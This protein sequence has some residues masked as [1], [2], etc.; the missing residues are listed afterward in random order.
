MERLNYLV[1]LFRHKLRLAALVMLVPLVA[2]AARIPTDLEVTG[3]LN[4]QNLDF[5]ANTVRSTNTNGSITLAP[6]GTGLIQLNGN[7]RFGTLTATTVPYLDANK[8]LQ[9]SAVTPTELGYLS[10]V[11]SQLAGNDDTATLTNKTLTSPIVGTDLQLSNQAEAKFYEQTVNGTNYT[12]LTGADSIGSDV[13]FKLPSS[14]G[15]AGEVI[16]TDGS[17]NLS[18][19]AI[20]VG[21]FSTTSATG[22]VSVTNSTTLLLLDTSSGTL[23]A[24]LFT[25]V[26][27][28]G[29]S[30]VIKKI[31]S[32]T[33]G[34]IIDPNSSETADGSAT[35]ALYGPN[36][37]LQLVSDNS[38][39]FVLS[40]YIRKIRAF[41]YSGSAQSINNTNEI[42][43]F[44]TVIDDPY[45]TV[46]TGAEWQFVSP[47]PAWYYV[48]S[49]VAPVS[50]VTNR[51]NLYK[52]GVFHKALGDTP[53]V[54][55]GGSIGGSVLVYL[56]RSDVIDVRVTFGSTVNTSA[57][58]GNTFIDIMEYEP[59]L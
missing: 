18:F 31:S 16:Q 5:G 38:N 23:T 42:V 28:E 25:A 30:I 43:N 2:L 41:Y 29:K 19:T 53:A 12:G 51:V 52:N 9:S 37:T 54:A 57:S 44:D 34:A 35:I 59:G 1:D 13:T 39:W 6:N 58:S 3:S 26:G 17:R 7:T 27:N 48:S 40:K 45:S 24:D 20:S 10:G 22:D 15:A 4:V 49:R 11:A 46:T 14:D 32:D 33:N 55:V 50:A 47:K 56:D 21:D 36:D 8:D